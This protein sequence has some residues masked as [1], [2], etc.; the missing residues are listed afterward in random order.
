MAA[1]P[2]VVFNDGPCPRSDMLRAV[3]YS[4]RLPLVLVLLTA[5][6]SASGGQQP[7]ST[8]DDTAQ[9]STLREQL[10]AEQARADQLTTDLAAAQAEIADLD[11][12]VA[13]LAD[14]LAQLESQH[15]D[16]QVESDS[17]RR[18]LQDT[19]DREA[20]LLGERGA[21]FEEHE[22]AL[23][24]LDLLIEAICEGVNTEP[25][26]DVPAALVEW[27]RETESAA[28]EVPDDLA[29]AI[30]DAAGRS[31]WWVLSAEFDT[32]FQPG[33]FLLDPDGGF[34]V[35]WGGFAASETELWTY[36]L[37]TYPNAPSELATCLDLS[38]F[39]DR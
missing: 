8:Q 25:P 37:Q 26:A 38:P 27:L 7:S 2:G 21:L 12:V 29:I 3:A 1:A 31:G 19:Q 30:I 34:Q 22:K 4:I 14:E 11:E 24:I 36:L 17:L 9:L 35:I 5:S 32:R 6:C 18:E 28:G 13:E 39:V 15:R 23:A 16:V 10:A 20:G 33:V